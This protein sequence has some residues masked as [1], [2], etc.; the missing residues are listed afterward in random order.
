M[1]IKKKPMKIKAPGEGGAAIADRFRLDAP[2]N[3]KGSKGSTVGKTAAAWAFSLGL[4]A[5][6]VV[7]GLT[8][9]LYSHL[10]YLKGV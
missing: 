5:L 7:A 3:G 4:V 10:E 9:M 8:W 6:A 1:K 2:E